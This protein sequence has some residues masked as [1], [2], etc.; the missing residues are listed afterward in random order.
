MPMHIRSRFAVEEL[1]DIQLA[2]PFAFT[3]GCRLMR[4]AAR[5][6]MDPHPFGTLLYD[7]EQDP[8]QQ[9]PMR[10]DDIERTM[11]DHM[12][13]LMQQNDSPPDQYERLGLPIS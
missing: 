3:K 4:V 9:H 11:I 6:R 2:E 13:R 10:N 8:A 7:L 5:P 1:A 12:V